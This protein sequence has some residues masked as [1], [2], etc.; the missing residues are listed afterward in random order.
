MAKSYF[1]QHGHRMVQYQSTLIREDGGPSHYLC[2]LCETYGQAA[3][4]TH[5]G[6]APS[7]RLYRICAACAQSA[8]CSWIGHMETQDMA[9]AQQHIRKTPIS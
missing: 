4:A 3:P 1:G 2:Y 5:I 6:R 9:A 8:R 7:G